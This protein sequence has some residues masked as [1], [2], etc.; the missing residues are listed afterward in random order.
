MGTEIAITVA[1]EETRVAVLDGDRVTHLEE[2]PA[3][4]RSNLALVGIWMVA[5]AVV[6]EMRAH[7]LVSPRGEVELSGTLSVMQAEPERVHRVPPRPH[8]AQPQDEVAG[9]DQP[10]LQEGRRPR[11]RIRFFLNE[12][13]CGGVVVRDHCPQMDDA[14][15][16]CV[17]S[18]TNCVWSCLVWRH[19]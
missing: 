15:I 9:A 12:F 3:E 11:Q 19:A 4:P 5:P 13:A 18:W 16:I 6:A 17:G 2:K 14:L 1:R 8:G 10:V 7:P